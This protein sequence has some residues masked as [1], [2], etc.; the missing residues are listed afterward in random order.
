VDTLA[1]PPPTAAEVTDQETQSAPLGLGGDTASKP[2]R[3]TSSS[4]GEKTRLS[5]EKKVPKPPPQP[6][7]MTPAA[8]VPGAPAPAPAPASGTQPQQ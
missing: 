7:Q 4:T 8:P 3:K 2:K 5:D 6:I 1:P